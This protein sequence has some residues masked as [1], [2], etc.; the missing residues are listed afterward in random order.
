MKAEAMSGKGGMENER[1]LVLWTSRHSTQLP[2][3]WS[4]DSL[5]RLLKARSSHGVH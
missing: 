4:G 3:A 1:L 5:W 2:S